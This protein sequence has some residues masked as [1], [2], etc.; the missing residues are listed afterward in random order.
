MSLEN[1][2]QEFQL[3]QVSA[4][5]TTLQEIETPT[6]VSS[7]PT[8]PVVFPEQ[9]LSPTSMLASAR[10]QASTNFA[11]NATP[12]GRFF[13][14]DASGESFVYIVDRSGS[15]QGARFDR[16]LRELSRSINGLHPSQSFFVVFFSSSPVLM[17]DRPVH[18]A[19][20]VAATSGTK[21]QFQE[22]LQRLG[23]SGNTIPDSSLRLAID[24][25]PS[26]IFFL[27]DGEFQN[28]TSAMNIVQNSGRRIPI[29][30]IAFED[31]RSCRNMLQVAEATG[32]SYRFIDSVR[33]TET[34]LDEDVASLL[35]TP[36]TPA[37][38]ESLQEL[39]YAYASPIGTYQGRKR[40]IKRITNDFEN[41]YGP[42][43]TSEDSPFGI[44]SIR[45][46][47]VTLQCLVIND[48][49]R[50]FSARQQNELIQH[51]A[52][53]MEACHDIKQIE[54]TCTTIVGWRPERATRIVLDRISDQF[55]RLQDDAVVNRCR[56]TLLRSYGPNH[57]VL[58]ALES[59]RQGAG[60]TS[61]R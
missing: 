5:Q 10:S 29:H 23:P 21:Q 41:V 19:E 15:M 27:S 44:A 48:P 32:G 11:S 14:V 7:Q 24:L 55:S 56:E 54:T 25:D 52:F 18:D 17:F 61:A 9:M 51:L 6:V 43:K 58:R 20:L 33:R 36:L 13:G 3:E 42:T 37:R 31:R 8:D 30:T 40:F 4:P 35:Q 34:E 2:A 47:V 1:Q 45:V 53:K 60:N 49:K 46:T 38:Q 39:A 50:A 12:S 59:D 28:A 26:A 57:R 16:A 22:W